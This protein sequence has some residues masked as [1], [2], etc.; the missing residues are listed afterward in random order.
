M[1]LLFENLQMANH[2]IKTSFDKQQRCIGKIIYQTKFKS[3][4][5]GIDAL[6][7]FCAFIKSQLNLLSFLYME[8]LLKLKY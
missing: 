8:F 6:A 7:V 4:C 3:K 2:L 1:A 5:K